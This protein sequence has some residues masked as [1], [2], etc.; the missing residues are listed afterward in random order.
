MDSITIEEVGKNERRC[1][2]TFPISNYP[3]TL[4]FSPEQP[5]QGRDVEQV[6]EKAVSL[7]K[8]ILGIKG[9]DGVRISRNMLTIIKKGKIK[10]EEI[11]SDI[12]KAFKNAYGFSGRIVPERGF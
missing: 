10:W 6:G 3:L 4:D 1:R 9:I 7:V 2:T 5:P 8:E 12:I 11:E